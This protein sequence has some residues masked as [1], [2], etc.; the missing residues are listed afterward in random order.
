MFGI[1][2]AMAFLSC[3]STFFIAHRPAWR[4]LRAE[5]IDVEPGVAG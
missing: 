4:G 3:I 2:A 1:V 5:A